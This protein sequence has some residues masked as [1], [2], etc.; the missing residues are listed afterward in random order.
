[1]AFGKVSLWNHGIGEKDKFELSIFNEL[2]Y[3]SPEFTEYDLSIIGGELKIF[4]KQKFNKYNISIGFA[5]A[6]TLYSH[7]HELLTEDLD[8]GLTLRLV[9]RSYTERSVKISYDF[10]VNENV[11]AES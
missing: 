6:D 11:V 4:T 7:A 10:P 3:Y 8:D 5:Q 1:M 2:Q 9:D